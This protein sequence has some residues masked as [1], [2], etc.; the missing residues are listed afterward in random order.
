[1][2]TLG[3]AREAKST[4]KAS[5]GKQ[6][7]LRGI[8]IGSDPSGGAVVRVNVVEDTD[9][10][11]KIVPTSVRGVAVEIHVVGDAKALA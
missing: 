5:L 7:W 9:D 2:A 8:G 11:R 3:E 1:M 10:V 4:L 6:A